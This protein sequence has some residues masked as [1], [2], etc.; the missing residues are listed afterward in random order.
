MMPGSFGR[1]TAA[2]VMAL[3]LAAC[4]TTESYRIKLMPVLGSIA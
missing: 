2:A 4:G 3:V 1:I